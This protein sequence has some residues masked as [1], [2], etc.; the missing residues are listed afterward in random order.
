MSVTLAL[1][2]KHGLYMGSWLR[3]GS[4]V[5]NARS[6]VPAG[7][8]S[9]QFPSGS[10][11]D[12]SGHSHLVEFV[13]RPRWDNASIVVKVSEKAPEPRT[14]IGLLLGGGLAPCRE[15]HALGPRL[16][17]PVPI[18]LWVSFPWGHVFLLQIKLQALPPFDFI[19]VLG[20]LD[21]KSH[22]PEK[23]PDD[24]TFP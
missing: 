20:W 1:P 12:I 11:E 2:D 14:C 19:P 23:L 10:G 5:Y 22:L 6:W 17:F 16:R 13:V 4:P 9:S 15:T 18:L 8:P 7:K 21:T 24:L 3:M